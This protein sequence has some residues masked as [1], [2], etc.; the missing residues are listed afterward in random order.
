MKLRRFANASKTLSLLTIPFVVLFLCSVGVSWGDSV[1]IRDSKKKSA[2]RNGAFDLSTVVS[3]D[4]EGE[5]LVPFLEKSAATYNFEFLL[6]RR[7]D[8]ERTISGAFSNVPFLVV[9]KRILEDAD[10]YCFEIND[11]LLYIGSRETVGETLLALKLKREEAANWP[12][13][14]AERM[15]STVDLTIPPAAETRELFDALAQKTRVKLIGAE[16]VQFDRVRG[17]ALKD[18]PIGDLSTLITI[19]YNLDFKYDPKTG[20]TRLV[21]FDK[22]REVARDYAQ[23]LDV[24]ALQK[25]FP[26]CAFET[27]DESGVGSARVSGAFKDVAHIEF[28]IWRLDDKKKT[29]QETKSRVASNDS[30][31]TT[32]TRPRAASGKSRVEISGVIKNKTLR[33]IFAYLQKNAGVECALDDSLDGSEVSLDSR[34]SCEFNGADLA[35]IAATIARKLDVDYR[36]EDGKILFGRK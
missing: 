5:S 10:L 30:N 18:V 16:Y 15:R 13:K 11:S 4:F 12:K 26:T 3:V 7:V 32:P 34:V 8:P 22:E 6:D 9:L 29:A 2:A 27:N 14:S 20:E 36:I 17:V 1:K 28:E 24:F 25:N 35:E 31:G 21:A 23:G 33:D 19:G